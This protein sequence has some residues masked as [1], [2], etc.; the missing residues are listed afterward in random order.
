MDVRVV[1]PRQISTTAVQGSNYAVEYN[2]TRRRN[3]RR[4]MDAWTRATS[5]EVRVREGERRIDLHEPTLLRRRCRRRRRR[6]RAPAPPPPVLRRRRRPAARAAAAAP[7]L[8]PPS[9]SRAAPRC[10]PEKVAG[11]SFA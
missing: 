9:R 5:S 1:Q 7:L 4:W 3:I 8:H 10:A 11:V 2:Q 6:E